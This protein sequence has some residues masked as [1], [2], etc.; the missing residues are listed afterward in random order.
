[1][2]YQVFIIDA[3]VIFTIVQHVL[4]YLAHADFLMI[5]VIYYGFTNCVFFMQN[6]LSE[7]KK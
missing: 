2:L 4:L 5:L 7:M 3:I 1:M 6:A